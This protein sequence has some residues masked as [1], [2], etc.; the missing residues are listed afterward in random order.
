MERIHQISNA[1]TYVFADSILC[2]GGLKEN[3]N[4]AWKEKMKWSFE[5]NHLKDL[6]RVDGE[7]EIFVELTCGLLEKIQERMIQSCS[8]ARSSSCQC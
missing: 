3:P 8:K 4:E 7:S 5:N 1:K 6:N 2:L